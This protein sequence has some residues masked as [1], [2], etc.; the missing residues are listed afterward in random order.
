MATLE[1]V[2]SGNGAYRPWALRALLFAYGA[3][4]R[5]AEAEAAAGVLVSEYD[6]SPHMLFG[7]LA[8]FR[9]RLHQ[10]DLDG[11]EVALSAAEAESRKMSA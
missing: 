2:A 4:N 1:G 6:A 7:H 11:A 5:F 8:H 10:D 3:Q 9:L